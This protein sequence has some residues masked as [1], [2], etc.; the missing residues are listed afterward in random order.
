MITPTR[1]SLTT[2]LESLAA[3]RAQLPHVHLQTIRYSFVFLILHVAT[4]PE[5]IRSTSTL[6]L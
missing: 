5:H 2:F 1:A 3:S 6:L 4:V